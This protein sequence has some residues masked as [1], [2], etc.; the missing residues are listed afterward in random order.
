MLSG[1]LL[2]LHAVEL[3]LDICKSVASLNCYLRH[4][5]FMV[6]THAIVF[7]IIAGKWT[8]SLVLCG[9]Y[10]VLRVVVSWADCPARRGRLTQKARFQLPCE[11]RLPRALRPC[12]AASTGS[13]SSAGGYDKYYTIGRMMGISVSTA[14]FTC[15]SLRCS[16]ERDWLTTMQFFVFK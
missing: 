3:C 14:Q 2:K 4:I 12:A 6:R 7:A 5:L 10:W 8:L 16:L 1:E 13:C 15:T 11:N 9:W